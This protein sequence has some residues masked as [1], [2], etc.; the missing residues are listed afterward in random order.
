MCEI[1]GCPNAAVARGLCAK[2]YMRRRRTGDPTVTRN[3]GPNGAALAQEI[4]GLR[5][6]VIALLQVNTALR[7]KVTML[8]QELAQ[9]R[10]MAQPGQQATDL[11]NGK[12]AQR[13]EIQSGTPK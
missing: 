5:Q 11:P 9:Q 10:A 8:E 7:Q 12:I 6:K 2:H 3:P 4:T 13:L 1:S